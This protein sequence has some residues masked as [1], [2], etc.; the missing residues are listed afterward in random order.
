[1]GR[2]S[3]LYAANAKL[4]LLAFVFSFQV[5]TRPRSPRLASRTSIIPVETSTPPCK[6]TS[7]FLLFSEGTLHA[8]LRIALCHIGALVVQLLAFGNRQLYLDQPARQ[9]NLKRNQ[10]IA[11]LLDITDELVDFPSVEQEL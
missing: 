5:F 6:L 9:I 8:A 1:M 2:T 3:Q 7:G 10:G 4:S 11:P